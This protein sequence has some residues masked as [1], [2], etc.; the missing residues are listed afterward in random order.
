MGDV[1]DTLSFSFMNKWVYLYNSMG[2]MGM[3]WMDRWI[4]GWMDG[5]MGCRGVSDPSYIR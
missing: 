1:E 2:F 5:W 3:E 4:A